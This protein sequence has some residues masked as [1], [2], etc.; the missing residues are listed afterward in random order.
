M[1]A[2]Y[3]ISNIKCE[4]KFNTLHNTAFIYNAFYMFSYKK[5][6]HST[7]KVYNQSD[8]TVKVKPENI[9]DYKLNCDLYNIETIGAI[10]Q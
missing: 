6:H 9:S 5:L 8:I 4:V 2:Y 3:R 10:T 7:N 1:W